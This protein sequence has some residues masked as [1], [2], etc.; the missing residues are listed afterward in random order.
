M[1]SSWHAEHVAGAPRLTER[2]RL[3]PI[4]STHVEDLILLHEHDEIAA[5]HGG[6]W[7]RQRAEEFARSCEAR[8]SADGISKWMA[9]G[10]ASGSLI[11]R[12]GLS[13][14][15]IEGE[16]RLE[17]GWTLRRE[18]WGRGFAT[19]IGQAG[20]ACAFNELA[21]DEVVAFTESHNAR[22]LAVMFRLGMDEVGEITHDG[23][24]FVLC[25]IA[26]HQYAG[27]H[28][29]R[30]RIRLLDGS[31]VIAVSFD[32][33]APYRRE[34]PPDFGLYLDP[35]WEPPWDHAYLDWPDFGVPSDE[36]A[37][38]AA[39]RGVLAR[40][41]IGERVEIGCIGGHGRTG[42]A[43]AV[44]AVLTGCAGGKAVAWVRSNYCAHAIETAEQ[45]AF[46]A[47]LR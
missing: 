21:A 32:P 22:S 18:V 15:M 24:A 9:Y 7:S 14:A 5:W 40:A 23:E 8:W 36:R 31:T 37:L 13:R 26:A 44:L 46:A 41:R 43:L 3:V 28:S 42:T 10:R 12:G 45:E 25:R 47:Q 11:G 17:V 30:S 35:C 38:L 1:A 20:L 4:S 19:E 16:S 33:D 39:L 34:R 27:R 6:A 2:L 29:H